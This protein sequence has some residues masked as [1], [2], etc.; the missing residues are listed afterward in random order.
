[1]T[2][3][4]WDGIRKEYVSNRF[5]KKKKNPFIRLSSANCAGAHLFL[6]QI[7]PFSVSSCGVLPQ[8]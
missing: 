5:K 4:G 8:C 7:I 2:G 1:M 6:C 3:V